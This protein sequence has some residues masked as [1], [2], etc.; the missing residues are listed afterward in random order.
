MSTELSVWH[1]TALLACSV[2]SQHIFIHIYDQGRLI[3][4]FSI[5]MT[6]KLCDALANSFL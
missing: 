3:L 5:Q 6:N 4:C 1:S 2:V